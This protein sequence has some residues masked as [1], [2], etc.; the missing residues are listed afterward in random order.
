MKL[1]ITIV[2]IVQT[3]VVLGQNLIEWSE[4]VELKFE[5]FQSINTQVGET[6]FN[7]L[8]S[9]VSVEFYFQMS[10]LEFM[11]TKN[12]NN[13]VNCFFQKD[14]A[15]IVAQNNDVVEDMVRFS[16]YEFDL[17][18]LYARKIRKKLFES[19]GAFSDASFFRPIYDLIIKEYYEKVN[20]AY[21]T[22]ETGKNRALID[23][24]H[25]QTQLKINELK[26]FCKT[27]KPSKKQKK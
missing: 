6:D 21:K 20:E 12:F 17:A 19:K 3:F 2:F 25:K 8:R 16:N 27:C 13:K 9:G 24:L 5:D 23:D 26:D 1:L 11:M 15:M 18:E 4:G 10:N 22:T 7:S 14:V